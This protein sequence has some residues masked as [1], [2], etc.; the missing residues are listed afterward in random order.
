MSYTIEI[1]PNNPRTPINM[2]GQAKYGMY[3]IRWA[4]HDV[5][6]ILCEQSLVHDE[7]QNITRNHE[8]YTKKEYGSPIYVGLE[9]GQD[10]L[11][12]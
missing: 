1:A 12:R 6:R 10:H 7:I 3:T 5:T 11:Y 8:S 9:F 2:P 4:N